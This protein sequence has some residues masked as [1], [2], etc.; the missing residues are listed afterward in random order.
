MATAILAR[1]PFASTDQLEEVSG[2]GPAHADK[3]KQLTTV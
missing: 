3:L 1:R 2:I